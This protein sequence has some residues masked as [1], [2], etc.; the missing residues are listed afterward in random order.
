MII[1]KIWTLTFTC[2]LLILNGVTGFVIPRDLDTLYG[3][4]EEPTCHMEYK[5]EYQDW[6][7]PY[8]EQTCLTQNKE[9]CVREELNN[10]TT[11]IET[12]LE[13]TCVNV[14]E[15]V[16]NLVE[17]IHYDTVHETYQVM[18]CFYSKD[19]VCDTVYN[20]ETISKDNY[21]CVL[22]ETPNC[23]LSEQVIND[24]ICTDTIDF[25]CSKALLPDMDKTNEVV[26][27]RIPRK[28]C[29]KIPRKVLVE[30]CKQDNYDYCEKLTNNEPMPVESQNCHFVPKKFC[31]VRDRKRARKVKRYSYVKECK[32][33]V[34]Q[35]CHPLERNVVKPRCEKQNRMKCSYE[36]VEKCQEMDKLFC[37]KVDMG[38]EVEICDRKFDTNYL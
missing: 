2:L 9:N 34:R 7:E 14:T 31:L 35:I 6:C 25:Q 29:Y 27:A 13:R 1:L 28:D 4:E 16:C 22:V 37:Q 5:T 3:E 18:S 26:C 23:Y 33:V 24:V 21:H 17:N 15:M 12:S 11:V 20:M 19:M 30:V 8:Q 32:Q 10:C 36:P 38:T